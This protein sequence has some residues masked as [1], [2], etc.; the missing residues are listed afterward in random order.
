MSNHNV[1]QPAV[2]WVEVSVTEADWDYA[3]PALLTSMFTQATVIRVFEEYVLD[4]AGQGLI[5][6]PAHSSIG[7]EGGAVGSALSLTS[8]DV[9]NG[10]HRGHH[11]FLAKSLH[12]IAPDGIDV[13]AELDDDVR[14]VLLRTLAEICGL[15]RGF[16]RGR[17]GSMHLQWREAGAV[18]TN[19]IVGGGVPLAAGYAWAQRRAGTNAVAVTYFGDGATNIGSTLETL[20]LAAAWKLPICFF[21]ENNRY[22][23]STTVEEATGEPRL[24]ARGPG[25]GIP[26]WKVDGMDALAVHLVMNEAVEH[27]RA[28]NGPTLIEAD[29]YR[30]F[31]QN[32][33]FPGSAFGYRTK[34]EERAYRDRDPIAQLTSNLV[35]REV[36]DQEQLDEFT[37]GVKAT[38]QQLGD[39]ILESKP[40]G[41]PR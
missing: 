7:Q 10:T 25:F 24:S 9:V 16:C 8:T 5:H 37:A 30:Y 27:M 36:A 39:V 23:V 14:M 21:I 41:K 3:H 29:V 33:A 2:D 15:S 1:L 38:M 26:S 31:H 11:Q 18:G 34:D 19:A 40:G 20:N 22:A 13:T 35:R 12:H 28:G 17:G 4:L 32:G 6:G